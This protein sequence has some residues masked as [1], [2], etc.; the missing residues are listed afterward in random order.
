M[1]IALLGYGKMG[2]TIEN[3]AQER[4][5]KIILIKEETPTKEELQIVDIA[6]DFST[7]EAAFNNIKTCL[8][9][10]TKIVS[11]TTG[12][13]DKYSQA[14]DI[15]NR[16]KGSFVYSSNF[17][18]GVNIFFQLNQILAKMM[19]P[20]NKYQVEIEETHHTQKIDAPSGTAIS[21][22]N[23]IIENS[24]Y[25]NWY[26]KSAKPKANGIPIQDKRIGTTPGTHLIHYQS[27]IDS[28][29]IKHTAHKRDGFALGA[30]IAA[31]WLQKKTGIF[32]M[33]DVLNLKNI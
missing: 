32:D 2:Q 6:I 24:Q 29:E 10:N 4:G 7:P 20:Q 31:E 9:N 5:H 28:I 17:S 11:G 8:E 19:A 12:W 30:I 1:N 18:V 3:I 33:Q 13:L 16:N 25:S 26:L 15:C 27:N 21:L 22:A 23:G 14:V